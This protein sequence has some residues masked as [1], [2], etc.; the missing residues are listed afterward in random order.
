MGLTTEAATV[1]DV[2]AAST[3]G[4]FASGYTATVPAGG[5]V[6]LTV[7]GGTEAAGTTY[8]AESPVN[9]LAGTAVVST[10]SACSGGADVRFVGNGAPNTLTFNGVSAAASGVK[11][12]T[13]GPN[14][15][16]N[17]V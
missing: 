14:L 4:S 2:W 15:K 7:T 11:I 17:L 5:T 8:E 10:R 6:L 16:W 9:T 1:R 13:V 12:A 3:K